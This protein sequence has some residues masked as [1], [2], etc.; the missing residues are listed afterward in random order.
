[1]TLPCLCGGEVNC[2]AHSSAYLGNPEAAHADAVAA[3]C[4]VGPAGYGE[5][6]ACPVRQCVLWEDPEAVL[7]EASSRVVANSIERLQSNR[8]VIQGKGGAHLVQE[9]GQQDELCD[10]GITVEGEAMLALLSSML[11]SADYGMHI[12]AEMAAEAIVQ[13]APEVRAEIVK[14]EDHYL[15]EWMLAYTRRE[16]SIE[17]VM[18]RDDRVERI[19]VNIAADIYTTDPQL[20]SASLAQLRGLALR[21][22]P[23]YR[24]KR[25]H[26][27]S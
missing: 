2:P 4:V 7:S 18:R 3:V 14:A 12:R 20:V 27:R 1:M 23:A 9:L 6:W 10:L 24:K 5:C 11:G 13:N 17:E 22:S 25:D 15:R 19:K 21:P 16:P 8:T 26:A